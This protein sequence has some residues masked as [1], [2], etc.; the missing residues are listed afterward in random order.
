MQVRNNDVDG[1][2]VEY[3]PASDPPACALILSERA[4]EGGAASNEPGEGRDAGGNAA[5]LAAL[6]DRL[7]RALAEQDNVLRRAARERAEAVRFATMDLVKDLLPGVDNLRRAIASVAGAISDPRLENLLSGV[8]ATERAMLSALERHGVS[9]IDP[10]PGK[11]FDPNWHEAINVIADAPV[12]AGTVV[13]VLQ[14]GY[15]LHERLLRPAIVSVS[16]PSRK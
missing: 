1:S 14:P 9:R 15:R 13:E 4:T 8:A 16:G 7:L 10:A 6:R 5:E 11:P 2:L 3:F 12:P